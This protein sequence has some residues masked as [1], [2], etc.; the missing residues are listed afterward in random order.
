MEK[1]HKFGSPPSIVVINWM[2]RWNGLCSM[3][4]E[5]RLLHGD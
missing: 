3:R 5:M 1:F 4:E 2:V